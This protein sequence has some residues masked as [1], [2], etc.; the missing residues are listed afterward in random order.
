[1]SCSQTLFDYGLRS[2]GIGERLLPRTDIT[3]CEQVVL[4]GSGMIW[5][6]YFAVLALILGFGLATLIALGKASHNPHI[7]KLSKFFIFLF[8][9]TPLFL[10]FFFAYELFVLLPKLGFD[11]NIGFTEITVETRWLTKAWLGA[12]TVLFLNTSAYTAEIFYG[13]YQ[14]VPKGEV[15]AAEAFGMSRFQIFCRV[16]WPTMMRLAWQSY[17]NE[18]IFLFHATTLV[19][20]SS[21]PAWRQSGD[22]LYYA[23]YFAE[24]TFNPF[25]AYPI[26]A[27]YFILFTVLLIGLFGMIN[28]KLNRHLA[29]SKR[30][31][32][33]YKPQF[34]R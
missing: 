2:I 6:I 28:K 5:N 1:M 24:K 34:I 25:V 18:A 16:I 14:A 22:A 27:I 31:A 23:S 3:F 12:L 19:F 17:T 21:F 26:A 20:F 4:I 8:R 32:L 9:G 11:L 29:P 13:A 15:E 7:S 10:Q 30:P 33:K